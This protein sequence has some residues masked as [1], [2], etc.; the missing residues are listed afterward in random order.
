VRGEPANSGVRLL[1]P[2]NSPNRRR[3]IRHWVN[4]CRIPISRHSCLAGVAGPSLDYVVPND[5]RALQTDDMLIPTVQEWV[6]A[7]DSHPFERVWF[8]GE[9]ETLPLWP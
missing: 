8:M 1:G 3:L 2:G 9:T 6:N 5:G 4:V 7:V